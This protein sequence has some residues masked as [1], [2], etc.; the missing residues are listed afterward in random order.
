M[1]HV[2]RGRGY[3]IINGH[4]YD[5]EQG[6]YFA[7]PPRMWHEHANL[8]PSED[9]ILFSIND[10]PAYEALAL[11]RDEGYVMNGGHQDVHGE[12]RATG[13]EQ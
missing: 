3:S 13:V 6:D 7:L 11:Y 4:R 8:S 12:S 5:W 9:A 10:K 1:Y 2:F